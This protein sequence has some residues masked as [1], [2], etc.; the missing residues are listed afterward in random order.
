MKTYT[1]EQVKNLKEAVNTWRDQYQ[2]V[3][4][5]LTEAQKQIDELKR[6]APDPKL[7]YWGVDFQELKN[8]MEKAKENQSIFTPKM[9]HKAF[10]YCQMT[11]TKFLEYLENDGPFRHAVEKEMGYTLEIARKD[12]RSV[13]V[14]ITGKYEE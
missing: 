1:E 12:G 8:Y 7:K 2:E 14:L 5:Q 11:W 3:R 13:E 10:R 6:Y 4:A 9:G